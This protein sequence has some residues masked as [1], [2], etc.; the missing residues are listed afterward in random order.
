MKGKQRSEPAPAPWN[1]R[2]FAYLLDGYLGSAFSV[3]PVGLLW[4]MLTGEEVINTD[5][6]LFEAPYGWLAGLLGL[7]FGAVYYYLIPL[8]GWKGQTLGKKLMNLR[9]VGEDNNPLPPGRLAVRQLAGIMLLEGAFLLTGQYA[10][11]MLTMLT[12]G[13][14]GRVLNYLLFG[15]FLISTWL[16][17]R[18]G[19]AAHDIWV[20]S[21]VIDIKNE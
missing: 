2:G 21:K 19:R 12:F 13:T 17:Y 16:A 20:G 14:A 10:V 6:S 9:I 5:L 18:N 8:W 3:I 7:M 1:R 11:Q 4:N 15:V